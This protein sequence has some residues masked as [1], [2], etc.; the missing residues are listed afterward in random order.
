M[1]APTA[2]HQLGKSIYYFQHAEAAINEVLVLLAKSDSETTLILV[3]ELDYSQRIKTADVMFARF[4]DLQR[5][6]DLV[7]KANW[8]KL[9]VELGKLGER[10]N[11]LVHSKYTMWRNVDGADGLI[12]QNSNL[13]ASK[14]FRE[15]AEEE[16]LPE[17]FN[18]D[19]ERLEQALRE[20]EAFRMTI[21]NWLYPD[22][23]A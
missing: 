16:M 3:S 15:E 1:N 17:S 23:Q 13:R 8:H 19:L 20:I 12:R 4:V 14:G 18:P 6:P 11:T 5:E 9:M 21:I 22:V 7:A 10:R 2:F